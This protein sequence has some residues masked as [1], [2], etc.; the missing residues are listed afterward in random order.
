VHSP[1]EQNSGPGGRRKHV[2]IIAESK[3]DFDAAENER[4]LKE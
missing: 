1:L 3:G 4:Q 2:R